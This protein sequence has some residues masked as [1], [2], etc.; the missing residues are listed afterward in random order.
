MYL[1]PTPLTAY[2]VGTPVHVRGEFGR[3][4]AS[5]TFLT[6]PGEQSRLKIRGSDTKASIVRN[7]SSRDSGL[8]N[9]SED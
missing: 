2:K 3:T 4:K 1:V 7:W 8:A 9:P 5:Q 6:D